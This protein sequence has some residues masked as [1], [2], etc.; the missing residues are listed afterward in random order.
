[1]E[2]DLKNERDKNKEIKELSQDYE[3][4]IDT[5]NQQ[6]GDYKDRVLQLKSQQTESGK[7]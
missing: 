2:D 4:K 7:I 3:K 1:M 6:L 5:L